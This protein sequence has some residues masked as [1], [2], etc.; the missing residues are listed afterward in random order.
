MM[1]D[2]NLC[3]HSRLYFH[4]VVGQQQRAPCPWC[5]H[6]ELNQLRKEFAEYRERTGGHPAIGRNDQL[7]TFDR[8]VV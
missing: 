7:L 1:E 5:I 4:N 3:L 2:T 6:Q 8:R